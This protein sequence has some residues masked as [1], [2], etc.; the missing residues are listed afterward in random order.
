MGDY[1]GYD[2]QGK[3]KARAFPDGTETGP[4]HTKE[5]SARDPSEA[6]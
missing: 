1:C 5:C 4:C 2:L 6:S 3:E